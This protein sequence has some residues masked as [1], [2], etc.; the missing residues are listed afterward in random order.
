MDVSLGF[1]FYTRND[2]T[3][4]SM[5]SRL[6]IFFFGFLNTW[7]RLSQAGSEKMKTAEFPA[8]ETYWSLYFLTNGP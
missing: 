4:H 3:A 1:R 2:K 8:I 7:C 5:A 6:T